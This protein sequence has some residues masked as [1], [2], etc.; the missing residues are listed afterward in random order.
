MYPP[1]RPLT[2]IDELKSFKASATLTSK[3]TKIAY[4][5]FYSLVNR[6]WGGD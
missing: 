2:L 5:T 1:S 4:Y 6:R 3:G